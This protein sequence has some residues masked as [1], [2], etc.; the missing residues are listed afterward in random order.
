M[1]GNYHV[2]TTMSDGSFT[3]DEI[4]QKAISLGL[5]EIGRF[6][7]PVPPINEQKIILEY[8]DKKI[9]KINELISKAESQIKTLHEY[10]QSLIFS[11]VTGKIDVREAIT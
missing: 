1:L 7:I 11:A 2:H 3:P 8:V 5:D 9:G 6:S 4:V 10:R